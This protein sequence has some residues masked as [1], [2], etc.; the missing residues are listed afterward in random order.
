MKW[1]KDVDLFPVKV[2][3]YQ[4]KFDSDF[5]PLLTD[6]LLE[7]TEF[8]Q[9]N[10][11]EGVETSWPMLQTIDEGP[12][13]DLKEFFYAALTDYHLH[14]KLHCDQLKISTMWANRAPARS[15]VGHPLH[16]HP[17]S[18]ISAVFYITEGAPTVF[19]DPLTQRNYDSM[20]VVSEVINENHYGPHAAIDAEPGK[21]ILFPSWLMHQSDRHLEDYDRWTISFNALPTGKV[22][23]GPWDEPMAYMDLTK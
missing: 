21:L 19:H 23:I 2:R 14:H 16:R 22:N 1:G 12:I 17:M 8:R 20:E 4:S 5:W 18:Y 11:P 3:T 6:W 7:N 13:Y 9:N 10:F 15:G